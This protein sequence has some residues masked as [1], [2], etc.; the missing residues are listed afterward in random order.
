MARESDWSYLPPDI[1]RLVWALLPMQSRVRARAVFAAWAPAVP[2]LTSCTGVRFVRGPRPSIGV[3]AGGRHGRWGIGLSPEKL[4]LIFYKDTF[5][6]STILKIA[7]SS[8]DAGGGE[9]CA[10]AVAYFSGDLLLYTMPGLGTWRRLDPLNQRESVSTHCGIYRTRR[11]AIIDI[12][13]AHG[14]GNGCRFFRLTKR[15]W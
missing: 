13:A 2:P 3:G 5:L 1:L 4:R 8:P 11:T 9:D 15:R 10:A 7:F 14:G 6:D 12:V